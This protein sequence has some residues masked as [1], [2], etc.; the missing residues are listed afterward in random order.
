MGTRKYA[1]GIDFGTR[2][3]R[4]LLVETATGREAA[5]A[6]VEYPHGVITERLPGYG[7][8]LGEDWALQ[9]PEDYIGVL[10]QAVPAVLSEGRADSRD[11]VGVG[12]A[13]TSCTFLPVAA[14]GRPLCQI[15][16]YRSHPHAWV[17]LWK[18]HAA[19]AEA[20]RMT[21]AAAARQESFL[22][23]YGGKISSEWLLPKI[24]QIL[25]EAPEIYAAADC[26]MEAGD[27]IVM[28]LTG[29]MT[30][31]CCAAGYK[32]LWRKDSGFPDRGF[33]RELDPRLENLV[34]EKLRGELLPLGQRAGGVTAAMSRLT[35]LAAGTPVAVANIDAH[36]A[37]PA[38]G[39]VTPGALVMIM[40]T[41]T[42]HMTLDTEPRSIGGISGIVEDGIVPG[43][44]GFEAG[45]TAV[46]DI[47]EWFAANC[48]PY[49][50]GN[51]AGL[52]VQN[53]HQS[54]EN[55]AAA[56]L[57]GES[58][59]LALDWWNGVRTPLVD[60]DLSGVLLGMTLRTRPEEI[61]RAL[62]EA[63][64][65]GTRTI[66]EN[67]TAAGM[68][69]DRLVACGGL[70]AKNRLLVQIYAD[71]TG[72]NL[73]IPAFTQMT[74]LGAAMSGAVAA[75]RESGGYGTIVEAAAAMSGAG[76][77]V[78]PDPP[79]VA[80]YNALYG[81]YLG[82][83]RY[84]GR[85]GNDIMKRLKQYKAEAWEAKKGFLEA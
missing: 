78:R 85:G 30:R 11:V 34:Q 68:K 76:E 52:S 15:P 8:R 47:F 10:R 41:S 65:F 16:A 69:I 17:K 42:C 25:R 48:V 6:T 29:R 71:V 31:S 73:Y 70:P 28:R 63:T 9:D 18:H 1:L 43:L 19:A 27:W 40:G 80:R 26:F 83:Q 54:L 22:P 61:Y 79:S 12:I 14:D 5:C 62:L 24:W 21:E 82:L 33:F 3:G 53:V 72:R 2:S 36:A 84:F 23:F 49:G 60:P 58:G 20:G 77:T 66:L 46:G 81:E 75:G 32:A 37:V 38:T 55:K 7:A 74:A 51:A 39:T 59:L 50:Y 45:Q 57:P 67:F 64:A 4:V 35:G 13:F 44:Y 56:L